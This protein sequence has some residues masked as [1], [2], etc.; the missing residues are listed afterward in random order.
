MATQ[1][2]INKTK[3]DYVKGLLAAEPTMPD[4]D[5]NYYLD[6]KKMGSL[7]GPDILKIRESIGYTVVGRGRGRRIVTMAEAA[8]T[9]KP[10]VETPTVVTTPPPAP[11]PV[12]V[13][14][15]APVRAEK[16]AD[17]QL[18]ADLVARIQ[19]IM[20]RERFVYIEIPLRGDIKIHET[21]VVKRNLSPTVEVPPAQ[22]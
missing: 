13:T 5:I 14:P 19:Q 16:A 21:T 9:E 17:E 22:H 8:G 4:M 10:V 7:T 11:K 12:P 1:T 2:D 6:K 15:P 3:A 18:L 20:E